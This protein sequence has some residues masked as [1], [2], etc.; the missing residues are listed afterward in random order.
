[1]KSSWRRKMVCLVIFNHRIMANI[2]VNMFEHSILVQDEYMYVYIYINAYTCI[3]IYIYVCIYIYMYVYIYIFIIAW[4]YI[5]IYNCIYACITYTL[6]HKDL[7]Q[8][9]SWNNRIWPYGL[10]HLKID[11]GSFWGFP[12]MAGTVA[13]CMNICWW[14]FPIFPDDFL[15]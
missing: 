2:L 10:D 8:S 13:S 4:I 1:M 11:W 14:M 9:Y 12:S 7:R 15:R 5:F 6:V 3:Y